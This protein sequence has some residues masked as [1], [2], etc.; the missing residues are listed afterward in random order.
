M[1]SFEGK[2]PKDLFNKSRMPIP[3][4]KKRKKATTTTNTTT[5]AVPSSKSEN[6]RDIEKNQ[7]TSADQINTQDGRNLS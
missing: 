6:Y 7:Q 1:A 4:T 2:Y 5:A 3:G